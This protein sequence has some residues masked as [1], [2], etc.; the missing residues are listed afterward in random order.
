MIEAISVD[1]GVNELGWASWDFSSKV[2]NKPCAPLRVG[3]I[4][5]SHASF[6]RAA[7]EK[8][9]EYKVLSLMEQFKEEVW[10]KGHMRFLVLEYPQQFGSARGQIASALGHTL[11]LAFA[12]GAH[13]QMAWEMGVDIQLVIPM[14]WKGQLKKKLVEQ[15]LRRAIGFKAQDGGQFRSHAWDAVGVGMYA[16]GFAMDNQIFAKEAK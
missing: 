7:K 13:A 6:E 8:E 10:H 14:L 1:I 9:F 3:V 12:A 15:R 2:W 4:K 5:A 11:Q 16:K